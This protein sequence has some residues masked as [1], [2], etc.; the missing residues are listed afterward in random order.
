M[1][2]KIYLVGNQKI[3]YVCNRFLNE[4]WCGWKGCRLILCMAEKS[5]KK[6]KKRFGLNSKEYVSLQPAKNG[7]QTVLDTLAKANR[8]RV[9]VTCEKSE[10]QKNNFGGNE[11]SA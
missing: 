11:K 9:L 2:G 7:K 10:S 3:V 8:I 5:G 4:G 6:K 1:S